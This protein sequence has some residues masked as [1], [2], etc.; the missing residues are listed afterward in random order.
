MHGFRGM[1]KVFRRR[2]IF[3]GE[4]GAWAPSQ[5]RPGLE[6]DRVPGHRGPS[7]RRGG[8][9]SGVAAAPSHRG[10]ERP[11]FLV[12]PQTLGQRREQRRHEDGLLPF[13]ELVQL[14]FF[15]RQ[16]FRVF[17]ELREPFLVLS[18]DFPPCDAQGVARVGLAHLGEVISKGLLVRV[19]PLR[20]AA[21]IERKVE[22]RR[23]DEFKAHCF[24]L[25]GL[26]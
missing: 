4:E 14:R 1:R 18:Y 7:I 3:W 13:L 6:R 16:F 15:P 24:A 21:P 10:S 9:E 8:V 25:L 5:V 23:V 22:S 11:D 20:V 2:G 12:G 19:P 26:A 17:L